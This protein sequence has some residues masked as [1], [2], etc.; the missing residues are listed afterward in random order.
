MQLDFFI[1]EKVCKMLRKWLDEDSPV[2]PISVNVSR[3]HLNTPDFL[4]KIQALV[5]EYAI[6]V[7]LLEFELTESIF[8]DSTEAALTTMRKLRELGFGVS[9]DDFGAG[10]SSLN[11]LKDMATDVLKLDKEFFRRGNMKEEEKIIVSSIINMAKQLRMKVL[12]EGI[13]TE[14]QSEFLKGI[15]CDM[16]QGYLYAK[17]MPIDEFEKLIKEDAEQSEI[18][19]EVAVTD[20]N[21]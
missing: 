12:S 8:L 4:K 18:Q 10:F 19:E 17:P 1:Y 20:E 11:L 13:E 7:E 14:M 3:V 9:I 6:P 21:K 16:A 15:R 2:V 5:K